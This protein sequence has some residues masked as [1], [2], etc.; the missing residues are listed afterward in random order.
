MAKKRK[1][2]ALYFTGVAR[3]DKGGVGLIGHRYAWDAKD[4]QRT[5]F[6][7]YRNGTWGPGEIPGISHAL[8]FTGN[9]NDPK[10]QYLNL[11]RNHGLY[12]FNPPTGTRFEEIHPEREGFFMDLRRIGGTWYIVGGNYQVYKEAKRGWD[13]IDSGLY[14]PGDEGN[15]KLLLSIHGLSESD[16][17]TVGFDGVIF[18]YNGK[19]WRQLP[20]PTNLGLQRVLCV[21][22]NEI[23]LCGNANGVYRGNAGGWVPLTEP[24][25][26]VTFWDMAYF[27]ERVYLCTKKKLFVVNKDA[28]EEV[29]IPVKGPL[30]FYRMDADEDELWTCGNECLL[31]FDGKRWTQHIYPENA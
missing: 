2:T 15:T 18:R 3:I 5:A 13:P 21:S 14:V 17:Y 19:A 16:I 4:E 7:I 6:L 27:Q 8:R 12:R 22:K 24:D 11:D 30:G 23:Y 9:P 28:L 1:P 20:S 31:Q 10:R 25:E 26:K 29:K